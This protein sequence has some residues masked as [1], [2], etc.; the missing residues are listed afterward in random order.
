MTL[1]KITAE[2]AELKTLLG[3]LLSGKQVTSEQSTA[4][5]GRL[6]S[7][8]TSVKSSSEKEKLAVDNDAS[9]KDLQAKLDT[10]NGQ[11][12][13]KDG[14]IKTLNEKV[15]AAQNRANEVLASQ[16]LTPDLVPA[17]DSAEPGKAKETAFQQYSR[18]ANSNP[19][20]AGSFYAANAQKI[21]DSRPK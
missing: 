5:E 7:L 2:L 12:T 18:L 21:L 14:E 3:N 6:S 8:E 20:E 10:A 17:S 16:G 9:L 15:T 4:F 1:Q 19:R 13:A 11:V